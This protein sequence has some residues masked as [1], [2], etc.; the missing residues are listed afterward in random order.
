MPRPTDNG[1][2]IDVEDL[3]RQA[4][5]RV[6]LAHLLRKGKRDIALMSRPILESLI[7]QEVRRVVLK[8]RTSRVGVDPERI[9]RES[10]RAIEALFRAPHGPIAPEAPDAPGDGELYQIPETPPPA[11]SF[12]GLPL[13][14]GR[15][16]DLGTENIRAAARRSD[17][18]EI[19]HTLQRN[20]FLD[21]RL[22]AFARKILP[23]FN[24]DCF[25]RGERGF[26]LGD[27]AFELAHVFERPLRHPMKEGRIS[28]DEPEALP[29][30]GL[31][32]ERLLGRARQPGEI[33]AYSLPADSLDADRNF[34]YHRG[35]LENVL[36]GLGY[37]PRLVLEGQAVVIAELKDRDFTGIGVSCGAGMFNVSVSFKGLPALSFSTLNG[38]DWV[39]RHVAQALGV[40]ASTVRATKEG[41]MDLRK[42]K[43]RVEVAVAMYFRTLLQ[44]TLQAIKQR[45]NDA[46]EKPTFFA[47]VDLVFAGGAAQIGG[48]AEMVREEFDKIDFPAPVADIRL[49]QEPLTS[50]LEG[51]LHAALEEVRS[52]T[53]APVLVAP[54]VLDRAS[55]AAVRP[56]DSEIRRRLGRAAGGFPISFNE[57]KKN[58]S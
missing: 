18:G 46:P 40:P 27:Q 41:G 53:Q 54:S 5:S 8:Y 58:A 12:D 50:V 31:L 32:V 15:G 2:D 13:E 29:I 37:T 6:S 51:C 34:I 43:D 28:P 11:Q 19:V 42:P 7:H 39:D 26:V 9:E 36:G 57:G 10:K 56:A 44:E 25:I 55:V 48:F 23:K 38:G 45:L 21:L 47:P 20:V 30:V 17:D 35:V 16:L 4:S 14:A 33:C 22:D 3:I 24:V 49:S 1:R 52:L